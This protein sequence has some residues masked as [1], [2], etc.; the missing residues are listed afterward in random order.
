MKKTE[1]EA[2][3]AS[4]S[5]GTYGTVIVEFKPSLTGLTLATG[6]SQSMPPEGE[7]RF[8]LLGATEIES[9]ANSFDTFALPRFLC[10]EDGRTYSFGIG[11]SELTDEEI[12]DTFTLD[13]TISTKANGKKIARGVIIDQFPTQ[14]EVEPA[15]PA[16][17]SRKK[18]TS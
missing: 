8:I 11:E 9:T 14:W 6:E 4:Q 5:G 18:T 17:R 15:M 13:V 3:R 2:L 1:F 10:V 12:G 16:S 7:G